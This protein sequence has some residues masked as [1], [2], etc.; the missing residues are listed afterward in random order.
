MK[1]H[2]PLLLLCTVGVAS[3]V[4]ANYFGLSSVCEYGTWMDWAK[5]WMF[6]GS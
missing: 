1:R 3:F 4:A 5:P 6:C 2:L